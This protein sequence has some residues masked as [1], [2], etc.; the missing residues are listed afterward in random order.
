MKQTWSSHD[1]RD[2]IAAYPNTLSGGEQQRLAIAVALANRP[3]IL[4]ADEP[5]GALDSKTTLE[6]M[7][8]FKEVN[9]RG[10]TVVIV[11]HENE[12]ADLTDRMIYLKDGRVI[13]RSIAVA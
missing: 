8:I 13:N 4:L 7:N 3:G 5:T 1:L 12:I 11:T 2:A 6:V 10:I 9:R